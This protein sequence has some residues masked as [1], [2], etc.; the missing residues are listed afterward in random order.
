MRLAG[1]VC[2][3]SVLCLAAMPG[4]ESAAAEVQQQVYKCNQGGQITFSQTPC[5]GQA[6]SVEVE[7]TQPDAAQAQ[8][9]AAQAQEEEGVAGAVA[10][11]AV[12]DAQ[13]QSME[14]RISDLETQRDAELTLLRAQLA[15][16][17]ENPNP[18]AFQESMEAQ[19]VATTENYDHEI[20]QARTQLGELQAQ[21][22]ALA[23][24]GP[25]Q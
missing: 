17:T 13:I 18:Q 25:Q 11:A 3:F 4:A 5:A 8:Q 9:A 2:A 23:G 24:G 19:I 14:R 7:Y 12:L 16:G 1:T 15:A 21:R 6:Q 20:L 10:Q 22:E